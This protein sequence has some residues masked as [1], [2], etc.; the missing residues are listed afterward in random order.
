[1]FTASK[2][3]PS[4]SSH[5]T[6]LQGIVYQLDIALENL[7]AQKSGIVFIYNMTNSKYSN[8]DYELSQKILNLLKGAFPARLKKVLI[9]TAPL[10][11]KAPFKIL[12]LFVREKL[13]DRVYMVNQSHLPAHIPLSSLPT[14]LGGEIKID[15]RSWLDYYLTHRPQAWRE[16]SDIAACNNYPLFTN[17]NLKNGAIL[18]LSSNGSVSGEDD[19]LLLKDSTVKSLSNKNQTIENNSNNQ[20]NYYSG[21]EKG[22]FNKPKPKNILLP[23]NSI[24]SKPESSKKGKKI[25]VQMY[26]S[27]HGHKDKGMTVKEFAAHLKTLQKNDLINEYSGI[28]RGL[29]GTCDLSHVQTNR[30]K[31]RYQDIHCYDHSAVKLSVINN[32][33]NSA[34]INANYVDGY[35]QKAAFISTQGPLDYTTPDF[36]RM[37][38]EQQVLVIVMTTHTVEKAKAKCAQYWPLEKDSSATF[39]DFLIINKDAEHF[40]DFLVTKLTITQNSVG[41]QFLIKPNK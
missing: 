26:E 34:Y 33:P 5:Q 16:L 35:K 12:C 23:N 40:G 1:M 14:E 4:A 17:S 18:N 2:H 7:K 32:D 6:T 9:V 10:W 28:P 3:L 21:K 30:E 19:R 25:K 37:I 41:S 36:W 27:L 20:I 15:H 31:N 11:F 22:F 29:S 13:R 24:D 8:F 38:W 39:G